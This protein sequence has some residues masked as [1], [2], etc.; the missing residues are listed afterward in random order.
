MLVAE[1]AQKFISDNIGNSLEAED[2]SALD[3][4]MDEVFK[5]LDQLIIPRG[6]IRHQYAHEV[7]DNATDFTREYFDLIP[8]TPTFIPRIGDIAVFKVVTGIPVGHICVVATGSDVNNMVS[9]DQNWDTIHYNHGTDPKT[10]LLIPY[11]R[12]VVHNNYY[13]VAGFLRVKENSSPSSSISPSFSQSLSVSPSSSP[14]ASL[15]PSSSISPSYSLSYSYSISY[16]LSPSASMSSS[17]S[18]SPS[19]SGQASG[20]SGGFW[21]WFIN[22]LKKLFHG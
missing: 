10:G 15:S 16:S 12:L 5:Y 13:G 1:V 18:S 9:F 4:C 21:Q 6:T 17:P 7:W 22:F 3:Q 20:D 8:N 11:C 2:Y 19:P 14:S